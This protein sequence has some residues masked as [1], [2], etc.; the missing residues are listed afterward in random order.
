MKIHHIFLLVLCIAACT[1][2]VPAQR[3]SMNADENMEPAGLTLVLKEQWTFLRDEMEA[4]TVKIAAKNE[5]ETT[6]EFEQRKIRLRT[7]LL[8]KIEARINGTKLNK[9]IFGVLFKAEFKAY[10]ADAETYEVDC[11]QTVEAPYDIPT[12]HCHIPPNTYVALNDTVER[13][14]RKSQIT[15]TFKPDFIWHVSRE[16]ARVAKENQGNIYFRV[17]FIIDI[18]QGNITTQTSLHILP[19]DICLIDVQKNQILWKG[20]Q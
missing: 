5:F 11:S 2:I 18:S 1:T 4:Y 19:K 9:R 17:H 10:N 8:N 16:I 12:V 15:L 6:K 14:F 20:T 3:T 7:E 13:G